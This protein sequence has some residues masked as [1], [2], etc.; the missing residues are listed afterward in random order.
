LIVNRR[1]TEGALRAE[2]AL[3]AEGQAPLG[4]ARYARK[5]SLKR[6]IDEIAEAPAK[7]KEESAYSV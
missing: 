4:K 1:I 3:R 7:I 5:G 2:V 6:P